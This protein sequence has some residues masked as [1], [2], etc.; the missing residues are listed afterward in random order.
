M[1]RTKRTLKSKFNS[2]NT[3]PHLF[4]FVEINGWIRRR[5]GGSQTSRI[6]NT[7]SL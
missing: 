5:L 3:K 2:I 4:K 7:S 6:V 1:I